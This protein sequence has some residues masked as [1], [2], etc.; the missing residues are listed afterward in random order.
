MYKKICNFAP[1]IK[2]GT[3]I[4]KRP[5]GET[6]SY[7]PLD[8]FEWPLLAKHIEMLKNGDFI[9]QPIYD[10]ITSSRQELYD[11]YVITMLFISLAY[12]FGM[13]R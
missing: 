5:I 3:P 4:A 12:P 13:I 8:A 1:D 10:Y 7:S 11:N 2:H 9:E 6:P